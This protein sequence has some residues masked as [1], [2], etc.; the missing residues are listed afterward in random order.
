VIL[1]SLQHAAVAVTR[2]G[3]ARTII[4]GNLICQQRD[5][6]ALLD[7]D[8]LNPPLKIKGKRSY[9]EHPAYPSRTLTEVIVNLLVHRDYEVQELAEID[10]DIDRAVRFNNP[11]AIAEEMRDRLEIDQEGCFRP[12]RA[13]SQIR[14]PSIAD[15]FFGVR[16]MERVIDGA[17]LTIEVPEIGLLDEPDADRAER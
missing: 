4:R 8:E 5:L 15:V 13:L 17:F 16:S 12:V 1:E 10:I 14:N 11:G 3:K 9:E 6:I 2:K 7:S